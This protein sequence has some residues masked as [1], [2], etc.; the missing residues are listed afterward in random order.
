MNSPVGEGKGLVMYTL[1]RDS[2]NL[3]LDG[4]GLNLGF[5][6]GSD[7]KAYACSEGDLGSIPGLGRSPGEGNNNPLQYFCLENSMD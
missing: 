3:G 7:G 5:P 1:S 6:G 4:I 2:W